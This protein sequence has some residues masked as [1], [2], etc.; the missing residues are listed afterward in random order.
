MELVPGYLELVLW[1]PVVGYRLPGVVAVWNY[2]LVAWSLSF[3][4]LEVGSLVIIAHHELLRSVVA[5]EGE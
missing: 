4:F 2:F 3:R 1:F 5:G